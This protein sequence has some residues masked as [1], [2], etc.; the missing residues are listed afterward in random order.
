MLKRCRT[1]AAS[2]GT[3]KDASGAA[4]VGASLAVTERTTG[5]VT[6]TTSNGAGAYAFFNL[7]I[8]YYDMKVTNT[9]FKTESVENI[10]LDAGEDLTYD[11][12]L[13]VGAVAESVTV[14]ATA[15]KLDT[16]DSVMGTTTTNEEIRDLPL[17]MG[18]QPRSALSF[19]TTLS[20]VIYNPAGTNG[21]QNGSFSAA[22]IEGSN[23]YGNTNEA[24][25]TIDGMDAGYKKFQTVTEFS[26]IL[27]EAVEEL[28][29]ASNFNAEQGWDDGVEVALVTRSGT[30]HFHGSAF[31]YVQN[32]DL[33]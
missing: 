8:G 31:E 27:P 32:T 4:V 5:V 13:T 2:E 23:G 11:V 15:A 22:S 25:Y 7:P 28:R 19:L 1:P 12:R 29:L 17:Q 26:S 24:G 6:T 33:D 20:T 14:S 30:N 16:T 3:V 10:R 18:G 9:G 21:A